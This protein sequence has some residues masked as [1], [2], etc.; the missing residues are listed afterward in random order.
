MNT[1]LNTCGQEPAPEASLSAHPCRPLRLPENR[2]R[3]RTGTFPLNGSRPFRPVPGGPRSAGLSPHRRRRR[4]TGRRAGERSEESVSDQPTETVSS[5]PVPGVILA[6]LDR[7]DVWALS[8]IF[9]GIIGTGFVFTFFDIFDINVS[10][11]QTCI[12]IEPGCTPAN[13]FG[14]LTL[15][16]V[17]NL[18]G[19]VLGALV[20]SPLADRIG[21]RNMLLITM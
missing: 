1:Q 2:G 16:V 8:Y 10:F 18:A 6:R 20:L 5:E 12:Q 4:P 7:I 19:Y 3:R 14:S 9:I 17:L 11:V 13:A 21:R 15:P